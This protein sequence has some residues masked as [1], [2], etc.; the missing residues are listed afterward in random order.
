MVAMD[1][2]LVPLSFRLLTMICQWASDESYITAFEQALTIDAPGVLENDTDPENRPL[3]AVLVNDVS[4]GTLTLNPD[5]SFNYT[6]AN[7]FTGDDTF[8]YEAVNS[9]PESDMATVTITVNTPPDVTNPGNQIGYEHTAVSLQIS[10]T[11]MNKDSLNFSANGLPIGL[12]I[13]SDS[14]LISGTVVAGASSNSPYTVVV[15][16]SDGINL[17]IDATFIWIVSQNEPPIVTQPNDRTLHAG[18]VIWTRVIAT[19]RE[20]DPLQF[21]MDGAPSGPTISNS[22]LIGGRIAEDADDYSPYNVTVAVSD[23]I[24]IPIE[25]TFIWTVLRPNG[26]PAVINPRN[27]TSSEGET[28]SLQIQASDPDDD[29][30]TYTA[31]GLPHGLNI[32]DSDGLISGTVSYL[33]S[34]DSP[35]IVRVFVTDGFRDIVSQF[36]WTITPRNDPPVITSPENQTSAEGDVVALQ[37]VA[38]D[39]ENDTMVYSA[40]GLPSSL[41]INENSGLIAGTIA[42]GTSS[43]DPYNV[44]ASVSDGVN[45]PVSVN[46]LWTVSPRCYS[47]SPS[48]SP[49]GAG[50]VTASPPSNCGSGGYIDGTEVTLTSAPAD[51]Y[52]FAGW[53]GDVTGT[54]NPTTVTMNSSQQVTAS[55]S[56]M[57]P[58]CFTLNTT[59]SPNGWGSVGLSPPSNCGSGGYSEGTVVTLTAN[60]ASGYVFS[61]WSGDASGTASPTTVTMDSNNNV[62]ASFI[63]LP[64][65]CYSLSTDVAPNGSG[66]LNVSPTPNCPMSSETYLEGTM[67]TVTANPASGYGFGGW[68]GDASSTASPTTVTMD[69]NKSVTA[70]FIAL[71]PP[72][73]SL[74]TDV[75]PNGSG[76]VSVSPPSNCGGSRYMDGT[77]VTLTA[78]PASGYGFDRWGQDANTSTNPMTIIMDNNKR[79]IANFVAVDFILLAPETPITDSYGHPIY[80]WTDVSESGDYEL[81]LAPIDD[82]AQTKYYGI[83]SSQYCDASVCS[84]DLTTLDET[85][86]LT[87]G[88]Y[89]LWVNTSPEDIDGWFAS[90]NPMQFSIDEPVPAPVTPQ[91]TT[92]T[93]TRRPVLNWILEGT[94]V[95]SAWYQVYVAPT[96]TI[97]NPVLF[98]WVQ[99]DDVCGDRHGTQ[100]SLRLPLLDEAEEYSFFIQSWGPGGFSIGGPLGIGWAVGKPFVVDG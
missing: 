80:S 19:D 9:I 99:R 87:N 29:P 43:N 30:L 63:E 93:H 52:G 86:W 89:L 15:S 23:G 55:F 20:G 37:I 14:G 72:C 94:A 84:V 70:S 27:Q 40:S 76:N 50:T 10:A 2:T 28:V 11:D 45:P 82:I 26:A 16:V 58:V 65:P 17:P 67:V 81:Y 48:V 100:C 83:V 73:Y 69:S 5:G 21:S 92:E 61:M 59:I 54:A 49:D 71:P 18:D 74:S 97:D 34:N 44:E 22:G 24:N 60:P 7:G 47:L 33:A 53:S 31:S 68:S 51:G 75:A 1:A 57:P 35:Y 32:N 6:P 46:W 42:S 3:S 25:V 39:S 64:P 66:S 85:T 79:I 96:D 4:N 62:T 8:T 38:L 41:S 12:G 90:H 56:E 13:D 95:H 98:Q 88:D 78:N 77:V 91:D 36:S